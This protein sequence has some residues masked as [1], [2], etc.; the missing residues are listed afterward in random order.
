MPWI[1]VIKGKSFTVKTNDGYELEETIEGHEKFKII[2]SDL[3]KSGLYSIFITNSDDD[4]LVLSV[5]KEFHDDRHIFQG[6]TVTLDDTF[7]EEDKAAT[8]AVSEKIATL[9]NELGLEF[10]VKEG[11][12]VGQFD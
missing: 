2:K 8:Q 12:L 1:T 4:E 10:E 9:Y 6:L 3:E 7:S 11:L 5:G